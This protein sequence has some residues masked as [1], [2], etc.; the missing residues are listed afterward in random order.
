MTSETQI[1]AYTGSFIVNLLT[2]YNR[3]YEY[4]RPILS[5]AQRLYTNIYSTFYPETYYFFEGSSHPY[6]SLIAKKEGL[7]VATLEWT[8]IKDTHRFLDTSI[9][10]KDHPISWLSAEIKQDSHVLYDIT[11]FLEQVRWRGLAMPSADHI[12]EA[13]SLDS[14]FILNKKLHLNLEYINDEGEA[15]VKQIT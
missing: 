10:I 13:W 6:S 9:T 2:L 15:C 12:L 1:S 7:A 8:Y 4:S 5:F 11:P 14:G 3:V